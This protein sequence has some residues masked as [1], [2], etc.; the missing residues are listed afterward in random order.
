MLCPNALLLAGVNEKKEPLKGGI[1]DG[2]R[3]FVRKRR[4]GLSA[5]CIQDGW[6]GDNAHGEMQELTAAK[7][8]GFSRKDIKLTHRR[9][10]AIRSLPIARPPRYH[11]GLMLADRTTLA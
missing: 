8:H 4:C 2:C 1:L 9:V 5:H 3:D 11:S 7:S 6:E 10:A